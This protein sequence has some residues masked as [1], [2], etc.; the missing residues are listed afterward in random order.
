[1]GMP[2]A[3]IR[4]KGVFECGGGGAKDV[5]TGEVKLLVVED[6]GVVVGMVIMGAHGA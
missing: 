4:C 1:M 5:T 6:M 3:G 2:V